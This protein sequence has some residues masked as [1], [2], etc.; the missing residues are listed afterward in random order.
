[1]KGRKN[2]PGPKKEDKLQPG[3]N[4]EFSLDSFGV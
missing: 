3:P 4:K 2:L 1:M